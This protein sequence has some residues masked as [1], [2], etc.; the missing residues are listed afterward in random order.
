MN[1]PAIHSPVIED[2]V[3]KHTDNR[4]LVE[5]CYVY[6]KLTLLYFLALH[7]LNGL[8]QE[9]LAL[10]AQH[11]GILMQEAKPY[12]AYKDFLRKLTGR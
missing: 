8:K 3:V 10:I 2:M 4:S 6:I 9:I 11:I 5:S 1:F 12:Q 7:D